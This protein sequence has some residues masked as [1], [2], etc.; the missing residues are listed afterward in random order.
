MQPLGLIVEW[1]VQ[2]NHIPDFKRTISGAGLPADPAHAEQ[3]EQRF[4]IGA[5]LLRAAQH[6][7][8]AAIFKEPE[9]A[10]LIRV[11]VLTVCNIRFRVILMHAEAFRCF[12]NKCGPAVYGHR[13]SLKGMHREPTQL[14]HGLS[15]PCRK[16]LG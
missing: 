2:K 6:E 14:F 11:S 12:W 10:D 13:K 8:Q 15:L 16:L 3:T 5:V 1:L 9:H 4:I 7:P